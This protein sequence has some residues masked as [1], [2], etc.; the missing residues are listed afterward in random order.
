MPYR[1]QNRVYL[2]HYSMHPSVHT[3]CT[4]MQLQRSHVI[5][6]DLRWQQRS[7]IGSCRLKSD[8]H[9]VKYLSQLRLSQAQAF[10]EPLGLGGH[11]RSHAISHKPRVPQYKL[12][13]RKKKHK[14][15]VDER[16]KGRGCIKCTIQ[17]VT[18]CTCNIIIVVVYLV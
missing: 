7:C 14:G 6:V 11:V 15:G 5:H 16:G 2:V 9:R 3:A 18:K 12:R 13:R 10:P 4:T 1:R 17:L 8:P